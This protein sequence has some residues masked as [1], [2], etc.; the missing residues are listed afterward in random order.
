MKKQKLRYALSL[1][2]LAF[3]HNAVAHEYVEQ[4]Q[5][6]YYNDNHYWA[7]KYSSMKF[8]HYGIKERS[9]LWAISL[10]KKYNLPIKYWWGKDESKEKNILYFSYNNEQISF[11]HFGS[12]RWIKK[13]R[14]EW[15]W[16]KNSISV[17][18]KFII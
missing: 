5:E 15:K 17:F 14:W 10:I 8:K 13:Y 9:L 2:R 1:L 7:K 4:S 3:Q 11:H 6:C 12:F 18:D 16:V